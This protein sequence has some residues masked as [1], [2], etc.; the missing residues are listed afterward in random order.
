M[1]RPTNLVRDWKPGGAAIA[2]WAFVGLL[3][4]IAFLLIPTKYGF[5]AE[6]SVLPDPVLTPGVVASTDQAEV[7]GIIGGLSYSKRHRVTPPEMKA[8]VRQRYGMAHC[9]EIDHRGP[10]ALGFADVVENLWC[11][12]GPPEVWNYKLK[13]KL[14]TFVWEAVC[15]HHTMTLAEGQEIFLATDWRGPYCHYF[16]GPPCS[17][18]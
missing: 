8:A 1:P 14:E 3:V 5:G 6:V 18:P 9:G 4:V 17:G 10:L 11:Q 15:K 16:P 12:P 13:D 2:L 7:C